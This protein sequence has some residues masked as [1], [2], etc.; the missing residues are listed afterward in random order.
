MNRRWLFATI[1][2]TLVIWTVSSIP[3]LKTPDFGISFSDKIAH[4]AE[5]AVW[6]FLMTGLF[7][8][9]SILHRLGWILALGVLCGALDELHQLFIPGRQAD[10]FDFLADS[11]G[12]LAAAG[13][14]LIRGLFG[15]R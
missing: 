13:L 2:W 10:W 14:D 12:V 7:Q 3:N 6:G 15:K 5:Y 4:T 11:G 8:K 1:V 9:G